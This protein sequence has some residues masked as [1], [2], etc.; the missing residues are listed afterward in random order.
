M[1]DLHTPL[2]EVRQI[3][4]DHTDRNPNDATAVI[5]MIG[6]AVAEINEPVPLATGLVRSLDFE[7]P[8]GL[9]VKN[10]G[11][12]EQVGL[13]LEDDKAENAVRYGALSLLGVLAMTHDPG[14]HDGPPLHLSRDE[15]FGRYRSQLPAHV[16]RTALQ[17][18]EAGD[19]NRFRGAAQAF[20][21]HEPLHP[22]EVA[23]E[24]ELLDLH[25]FI[26]GALIAKSAEAND[27]ASDLDDHEQGVIMGVR[28]SDPFSAELS[29]LPESVLLRIQDMDWL[30]A[31]VTAYEMR[32][33]YHDGQEIAKVLDLTDGHGRLKDMK[34]DLLGH[35]KGEDFWNSLAKT[36]V[37]HRVQGRATRLPK[38]KVPI[39][40][41]GNRAHNE[42]IV[43]TYYATLGNDE[44]SQ[45][46]MALL[47]A[48]RTKGNQLKALSI[49]GESPDK[50]KLRT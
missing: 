18:L 5:S 1:S 33:I 2:N 45:P 7:T 4:S 38:G 31:D 48:L 42:N 39:F 49:L 17:R 35:P 28:V 15:F 9:G 6:E 32:S 44:G 25:K 41:V 29:E 8:G 23:I 20:L 50:G 16:A 24:F 47:A 3:L 43:R 36:I 34:R 40:Y 14:L 12:L 10:V 26:Q 11:R 27:D 46:V 21:G 30:N 13:I 19:A 37:R 22:E